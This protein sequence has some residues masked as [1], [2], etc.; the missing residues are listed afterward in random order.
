MTSEDCKKAII[1]WCA[2]HKSQVE[3]GFVGAVDISPA[4]LVK[5]WKRMS[6]RKSPEGVERCFDCIP[7]DDQLRATVTTDSADST[8]TSIVVE[9]E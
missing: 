8:I 9:G 1:Q 4:F 3:R 5:N 6:K 7:F 2:F